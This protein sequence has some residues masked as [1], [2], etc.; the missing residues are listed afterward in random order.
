MLWS[1]KNFGESKGYKKSEFSSHLEE[2]VSSLWHR[3]VPTEHLWFNSIFT[4]GK[5][6]KILAMISFHHLGIIVSI[7]FYWEVKN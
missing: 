2:K 5:T 4:L 1:K 6:L 3:S 7:K